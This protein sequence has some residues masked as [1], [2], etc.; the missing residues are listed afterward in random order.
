MSK[1]VKKVE[2]EVN[3]GG[4]G[5]AYSAIRK[6]GDRPF[7]VLK[8]GE[9]FDIPKFID[10]NSNDE[11]SVEAQITFLLSFRNLSQL[12]LKVFLKT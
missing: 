4:R 12:I 9:M 10:N 11:Q 5:S 2:D 6:L 7:T 8:G 3:D 1:Y